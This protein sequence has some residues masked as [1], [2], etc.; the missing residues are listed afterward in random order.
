MVLNTDERRID[1]P[2]TEITGMEEDGGKVTKPF[3][4]I[5]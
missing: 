5:P 1:D 4:N 2:L 3:A